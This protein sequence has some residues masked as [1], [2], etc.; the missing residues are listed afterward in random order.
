MASR[1]IFGRHNLN[2]RFYTHKCIVS[3]YGRRLKANSQQESTLSSVHVND[4]LQ[5]KE[6][7]KLDFSDFEKAFKAKKTS[8]IIRALGVYKLCSFGFLVNRNKELIQLSRKLLG[9]RG[10][11]YLMKNSF[12]GHFVAGE[13]QKD[14]KDKLSLMQRYGV[15]A[16]LDYAVE[17]DIPKNELDNSN[18]SIQDADEFSMD[19][20][21]VEFKFQLHKEFLDRRERVFSA[22]TYFYEGEEKCD[23]NMEVFL[24]CIDTTGN[25]AE[26]GFAA[27]KVTALGRP[28]LLLRLSQILNQTQHYFDKLASNKEI[29][30]RRNIVKEKF[31]FGLKQ[32]G[33]DMLDKE[34]TKIFEIMDVTKDGGIDVIEWH[35]FLTP[36]LQLAK[37]F[38]A[39]PTVK[40]ELS[41]E[42]ILTLTN[43]ELK[44]MENMIER[45]LTIAERAKEKNVR[46]MVDA[47]Q[48][49]F[50]PAITR[51]TLE[52]M[53]MFNRDK[54]IVFNTYQCYLKNAMNTIH[55]DMELARREGFYFGAKLVRGAYMEQERLRALAAGYDDPIHSS[56]EDTD[57]CY[58][59]VL[60]AVLE[61]VRWR[62]ANVMVAS[63]NEGSIRHAVEIMRDFNLAPDSG[64]VFFGQL[65]GMCDVITYA[66]GGAGYSAYKYVPYGPVEEVMPYLSRRA[67]ENR[68][69]MKGVV[70][71]RHMLWRELLRRLKTGGLNHD[72]K[73]AE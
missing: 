42:I 48:T 60:S 29:M 4:V 32:L 43:T 16:I 34:A 3:Q 51:I 50:Q 38:R 46:L 30:T 27:I 15:G 45:L 41:S 1:L 20:S 73:L 22:R 9:K 28:M 55:V 69:L 63:H 7:T 70:K 39:K 5:E 68:S 24:E 17:A 6:H 62:G 53:R 54:P 64:K 71:E 2:T 25:T 72:P 47:E 61:E 56:Y 36:Q 58:N 59:A 12:Y 14:I 67:M 23:Q 40:G 44:E 26:N 49:Y 52:A 18:S 31:L 13:T 66:L 10:F 33:V 19:L 37:L 57:K 8:E 65:L 21:D 11:E 35:N